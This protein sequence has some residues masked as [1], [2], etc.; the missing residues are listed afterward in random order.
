MKK[1]KAIEHYFNIASKSAKEPIDSTSKLVKQVNQ[2]NELYSYNKILERINKKESEPTISELK[3]EINEI[4]SEIKYL[5]E[6][7]NTLSIK[8]TNW[9]NDSS[10]VEEEENFPSTN[11]KNIQEINQI[12]FKNLVWINKIDGILSQKW[13]S[14]VTLIVNKEFKITIEALLDT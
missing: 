12:S 11:N 10:S 9:K 3:G 4:K 14:K 7:V 1:E 8:N 6:R 2:E 5:K 13:F